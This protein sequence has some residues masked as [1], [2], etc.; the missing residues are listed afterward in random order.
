M[1]STPKP[2]DPMPCALAAVLLPESRAHGSKAL[3]CAQGTRLQGTRLG[4]ALRSGGTE[5]GGCVW[6]LW[7]TARPLTVSSTR[8][9]RA[10]LRRG[11]SSRPWHVTDGLV[12]AVGQRQC[13]PA[14][15][16]VATARPSAGRLQSIPARPACAGGGHRAT[17]RAPT[18]SA[19]YACGVGSSGRVDANECASGAGPAAAGAAAGRER[20]G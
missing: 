5:A 13:R 17:A 7:P 6:P 4:G 16:V 15:G 20:M 10:R 9:R 12:R 3:G 11:H 19:A 18:Q 1:A 14:V 2:P 8:L